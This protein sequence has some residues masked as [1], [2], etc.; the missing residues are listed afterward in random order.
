MEILFTYLTILIVVSLFETYDS[1]KLYRLLTSP[2]SISVASKT[3]LNGDS[4]QSG[5]TSNTET[6]SR[7][8]RRKRSKSATTTDNTNS[9]IS[10]QLN[11]IITNEISINVEKSKL[12]PLQ[13]TNEDIQQKYSEKSM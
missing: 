3:A 5:S 13:G 8:S 1:F 9:G 4:N 6:Y 12:T 11:N 10:E 7:S 2:H